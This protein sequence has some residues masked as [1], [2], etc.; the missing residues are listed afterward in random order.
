MEMGTWVNQGVTRRCFLSQAALPGVP[1]R[2]T[3]ILSCQNQHLTFRRKARL[4]QKSMRF[5]FENSNRKFISVDTNGISTNLS[6]APVTYSGGFGCAFEEEKVFA[7]TWVTGTRKNLLRFDENNMLQANIIQ[8]DKIIYKGTMAATDR[9]LLICGGEVVS[10]KVGSN[11]VEAY[12]RNWVTQPVDAL[13]YRRYSASAGALKRQFVINGGM[14]GE[15]SLNTVVERYDENLAHSILH[16]KDTAT[17]RPV[18]AVAG[19]HLL[20]ACSKD[21]NTRFVDIFKYVEQEDG[22][23]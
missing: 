18:P 2:S 21:T 5:F 7:D 6:I 23:R 15:G 22:Y 4:T 1:V 16:R 3:A 14:Y 12:D 11:A 13:T 20:F 8:S 19:D 9:H 17:I 10:T